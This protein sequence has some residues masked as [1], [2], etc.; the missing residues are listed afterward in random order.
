MSITRPTRVESIVIGGGYTGLLAASV[1]SNAGYDVLIIPG[2][3]T[4]PAAR[5]GEVVH[6]GGLDD[7][8]DLVHDVSR[9]LR[10]RG[11]LSFPDRGEDSHGQADPQA[12][13]RRTR[14]TCSHELLLQVVRE[15]VLAR[16]GRERETLWWDGS[17]AT[18]LVGDAQQ[19][20][21]VRISLDDGTEHV[22]A[23]DLVVDASGA[24]SSA[25]AWLRTLGQPSVASSKR[26]AAPA[27]SRLY[28]AP[29]LSADTGVTEV[30]EGDRRAVLVPVEDGMWMVTQTCLEGEDLPVAEAFE[31]AA[32][33]FTNPAVGKLVADAEPVGEVR[34]HAPGSLVWHRF[35]QAPTRGL[36]VLGNA[37][38]AFSPQD[39]DGLKAAQAGARALRAAL[40]QGIT[41][42]TL[43][44]RAQRAAA[45]HLL[46]LWGH[47]RTGDQPVGRHHGTRLQ[48]VIRTAG[49]FLR[50][51]T[52]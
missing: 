1:L 21:G 47:P 38:A 4:K 28:R 19:V 2:P 27:A 43:A 17:Q 26:P 9:A 11:A 52:P 50:A 44:E 45:E 8:D 3:T 40:D 6:L 14:L 20:R 48:Q 31:T 23:A 22:V 35:D 30:V 37:F 18:G 10:E 51:G 13:P 42:P 7:L 24:G 5:P 32:L 49:R 16:P 39:P 29:A 36:V 41:H 33:R 12:W 46:E 34:L 25:T 15:T